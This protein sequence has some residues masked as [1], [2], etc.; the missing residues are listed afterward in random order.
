MTKLDIFCCTHKY[1]KKLDQLKNI[2]PA[3]TGQK[4]YPNSW[5]SDKNNNNIS[6]LN[7]SYAELTFHYWIWKNCLNKYSK[8][9]FFGFCQY[10]R[11]W[12][13]KNHEKIITFEN[14]DNN[15]LNI[16]NF[17]FKSG[18]VFLTK[19][20]KIILKKKSIF[21][22]RTL[23]ENLF[24][25]KPIFSAT[26]HTVGLQFEIS[27][28]TKKIIYNVSKYL[29]KNDQDDYL[30]F[31]NHSGEVNFHNMY[32]TN[33]FIFNDY[34]T[35]LFNWLDLCGDEI[36]KINMKKSNSTRIHAFLAERFL[37][38]WFNKYHTKTELPW[39]FLDTSK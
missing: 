1:Q 2:I 5:F 37:H 13:K 15:L 7:K 27:T 31:L 4:F 35:Y 29:K 22:N 38:F 19:P 18:E 32:I 6:H 30:N 26:A 10:R 21:K 3:G 17:D 8:N 20:E 28:K 39:I 9:D 23:L 25:P 12:L 36:K 14:L 24:D 34:M 11:F 16:D 33:K